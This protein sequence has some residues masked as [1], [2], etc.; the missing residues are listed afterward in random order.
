MNNLFRNTKIKVKQVH[1]IVKILSGI[2]KKNICTYCLFFVG[3]MPINFGRR[4]VSLLYSREY[5][6]FEKSDGIRGFFVFLQNKIYL[7]DRNFFL[8]DI[9]CIIGGSKKKNSNFNNTILDG[10]LSF[11]LFKEDYEFLIYDSMCLSG[12]WRISSW[13]LNGRINIINVIA[14]KISL[15]I[16]VY[17]MNLIRKDTYKINEIQEL[18]DKVIEN[19]FNFDRVYINIHRND[20]L[21]CN[22][23]DGLVFTPVKM[24]YISKF[25]LITFKWKY[26]N[27]NSID[28]LCKKNFEPRFKEKNLFRKFGLFYRIGKYSQFKFKDLRKINSKP[29]YKIFKTE[30]NKNGIIECLL[31]KKISSWNYIKIRNDKEKSNSIKVAINTLEIISQCFFKS[32]LIDNLFKLNIRKKRG[33]ILKFDNI[34]NFLK[35]DHNRSVLSIHNQDPIPS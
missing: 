9:T 33:K 25:P 11:N 27:G 32:E 30:M 15:F 19:K 31:N 34:L 2:P 16:N 17:N 13:D 7:L 6:V 18:F 26:E 14:N 29:F 10:E 21:I 23:N 4:Y 12:D 5:L 22:K 1:H 3:S 8:T 20:K 35:N 24:S 28:L